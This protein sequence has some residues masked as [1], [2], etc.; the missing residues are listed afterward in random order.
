MSAASQFTPHDE[1]GPDAPT[2]LS[3][4][5][6]AANAMSRAEAGTASPPCRACHRFTLARVE[7]MREG[8]LEEAAALAAERERHRREEH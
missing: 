6:A 1:P 7:A 4:R 8:R 5:V 2:D 3:T